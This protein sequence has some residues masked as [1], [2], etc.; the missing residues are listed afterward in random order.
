MNQNDQYRRAMEVLRD[1]GVVA[2]PT[3]T[4]FGLAAVATDRA[5]VQRV[6]DIKGRDAAN[7]MPLFV[8][9]VEQAALVAQITAPARVLAARFWP[10]ALTIV[11][12]KRPE[13][14]TAAVSGET[15]G[16][17]VPADPVLRE[18][19]AQLGPLTGTSA[20]RSG[21]PAARTAAEAR[22]ALNGDVDLIVDASLPATGVASTVVDCTDED[23][24]RIV[25]EGAVARADI[26]RAL[27]GVAN[28]VPVGMS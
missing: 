10:G 8:G 3:D 13:F 25:R 12:P 23:A 17:R 5:A 24:V 21:A 7:P 14:D 18:M 27:A 2:L 16:L 1:G 4:V 9:S 26:E 11:V 20:N 15:V 22:A 28:V 19:A 6:L